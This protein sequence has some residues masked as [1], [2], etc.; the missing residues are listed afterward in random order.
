M[1]KEKFKTTRTDTIA[2]Q[3][4]NLQRNF[5]EL[6]KPLEPEL[7]KLRPGKPWLFNINGLN[8]FQKSYKPEFTKYNKS[9]IT[10]IAFQFISDRWWELTKGN[11]NHSGSLK[12]YPEFEVN[13]P[14]YKR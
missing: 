12:D 5:D 11:T 3:K 1:E 6:V 13:A 8:A 10:E 4:T 7:Q 14:Y 2:I 9:F